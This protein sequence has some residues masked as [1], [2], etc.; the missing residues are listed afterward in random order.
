MMD[1]NHRIAL[2]IYRNPEYF[3]LKA[4]QRKLRSY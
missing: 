4:S 3:V 2:Q 1:Q